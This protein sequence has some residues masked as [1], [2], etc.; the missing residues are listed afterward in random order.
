MPSAIKTPCRHP[1]CGVPCRGGYCERHQRDRRMSDGRR[2][3]AA[4]RGYDEAWRKIAQLRRELDAYLCQIC[5]NEHQRLTPANI[6]DHIIPL[7]VRPDWRL[8]L[9]NTQVLCR[10]CHQRKT[11]HDCARFGSATERTVC[12][13]QRSARASVG[14]TAPPRA[15]PG[16]PDFYGP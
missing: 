16:G 11:E 14:D 9:G 1:G 7:H 4:E 2:G 13:A 6:V 15:G 12:P 5:L 8:E 10:T 3:N